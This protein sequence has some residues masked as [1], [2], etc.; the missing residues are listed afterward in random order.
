MFKLFDQDF[1]KLLMG[2]LG[3]LLVSLGIFFVAAKVGIDAQN[4]VGG[5][6]AANVNIAL[7]E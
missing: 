3:I 5:A 6:N 7:P 1:F 2:F 4:G